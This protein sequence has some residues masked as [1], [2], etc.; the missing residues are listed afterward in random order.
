MCTLEVVSTL[1]RDRQSGQSEES[2]RKSRLN[3][4]GKSLE[5]IMVIQQCW[6]QQYRSA[7]CYNS[8][9]KI[10]N[11]ITDSKEKATF[12]W[13]H[14][15]E[16]YLKWCT[17]FMLRSCNYRL[18]NKWSRLNLQLMLIILICVICSLYSLY[19]KIL[20][21]WYIFT[22]YFLQCVTVCGHGFKSWWGPY[23]CRE[24]SLQA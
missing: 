18:F 10:N 3:A 12:F 17:N 5:W 13:V 6:V 2:N 14:R 15:L 21:W 19:F 11:A 1:C 7:L 8:T 9:R 16:D 20:F 24:M 23:S 22:V 4:P